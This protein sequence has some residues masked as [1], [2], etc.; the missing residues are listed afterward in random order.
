[1]E[2]QLK[3]IGTIVGII[4]GEG[5]GGLKGIHANVMQN[6]DRAAPHG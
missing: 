4:V 1:M 5:D 6:F 3:F 2:E